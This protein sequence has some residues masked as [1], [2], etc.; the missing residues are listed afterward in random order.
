MLFEFGF[1]HSIECSSVSH[2]AS[3]CLLILQC[4]AGC[5]DVICY[6]A[7]KFERNTSVAHPPILRFRGLP[8]FEYRPK[9]VV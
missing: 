6:V 9:M 1:M 7:Q 4:C 8:N 2:L 5:I 3:R